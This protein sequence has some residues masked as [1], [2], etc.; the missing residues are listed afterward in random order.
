MHTR[1][2]SEKQISIKSILYAI[3]I[4]SFNYGFFRS[5]PA[6]LLLSTGSQDLW[7]SLFHAV[8]AILLKW[9][10]KKQRE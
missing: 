5:T 2:N 8:E 1:I 10:K 3:Y 9:G 6:A 4:Y 7:P